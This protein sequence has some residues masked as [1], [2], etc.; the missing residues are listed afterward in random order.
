M[1]SNCASQDFFK[2]KLSIVFCSLS[3]EDLVWLGV[4]IIA[5]LSQSR[6]SPSWPFSSAEHAAGLVHPCHSINEHPRLER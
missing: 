6:V 1:I 4:Q 5:R 2:L 3:Q